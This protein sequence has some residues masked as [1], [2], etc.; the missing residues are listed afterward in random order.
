MSA[1]KKCIY[2]QEIGECIM[3]KKEAVVDL[4]KVRKTKSII[5]PVKALV[6]R[7]RTSFPV[8]PARPGRFSDPN[9]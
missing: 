6:Q 7:H 1:Q 9:I 3:N 8:E 4:S 5:E 2:L